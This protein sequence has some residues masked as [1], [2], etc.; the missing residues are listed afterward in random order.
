MFVYECIYIK[1]LES[2]AKPVTVIAGR[3]LSSFQQKK[4]EE[5]RKMANKKEGWN[6][7]YVRSDAVIDSL[8]EA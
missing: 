5:R 1:A 2:E 4:E 3:K 7:S 6:A 8:A